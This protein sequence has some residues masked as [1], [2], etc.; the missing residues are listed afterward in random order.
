MDVSGLPTDGERDESELLN[1]ED[2]GVVLFSVLEWTGCTMAPYNAVF[3]AG[4]GDDPMLGATGV[5]EALPGITVFCAGGG[6]DAPLGAVA[7]ETGAI[8]GWGE[9]LLGAGI[10]CCG[11]LP[12]MTVGDGALLGDALTGARAL[13]GSNAPVCGK[14]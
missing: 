14:A 7:R 2:R 4:G 1:K 10:L 5:V 12:G 9:A 6:D 8:V 13:V 11:A 3:C